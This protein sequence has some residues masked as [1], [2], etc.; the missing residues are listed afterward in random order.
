MKLFDFLVSTPKS[1]TITLPQIEIDIE[2]TKNEELDSDSPWN[3]VL[4][5]D[6]YHSYDYVIEML[7]NLFGYAVRKAFQMTLE[8]DTKKRV[9]VWSGHLERAEAYREEIH[10]YG[11]D[12]RM[13]ISNGS[14]SAVLEKAR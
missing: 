6:D 3:V 8:V 11:A 10:A 9:I 7:M 1:E 5:D 13:E 4:L 2:S 12:P 14:M